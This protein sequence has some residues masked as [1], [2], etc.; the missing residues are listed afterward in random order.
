MINKNKERSH[1]ISLLYS[2][3]LSRKELKKMLII[4]EKNKKI[5]FFKKPPKNLLKLHAVYKKY[6]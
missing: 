4:C 3:M 2:C 6:F 1:F 5:K